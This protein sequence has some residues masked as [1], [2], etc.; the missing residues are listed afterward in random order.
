M[1]HL[2]YSHCR[3]L[4]ALYTHAAHFM[5]AAPTVPRNSFARYD[6]RHLRILFWILC[7][8]LRISTLSVILHSPFQLSIR[9]SK[10]QENTPGSVPLFC[11]IYTA[12]SAFCKSVEI[13]SLPVVT[14]AVIGHTRAS[15]NQR[16]PMITFS[17][18]PISGSTCP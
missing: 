1:Y 11:L 12:F 14:G 18:R 17:F 8:S 5:G 15:R 16:L 3:I 7:L 13:Y 2:A 9:Y 6:G 10:K 4:A